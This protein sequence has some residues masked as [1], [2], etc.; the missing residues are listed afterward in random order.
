MNRVALLGNLARDPEVR[1]TSGE[2]QMAVCRFC[3]AVNRVPKREHQ[4]EADFIDC[5]AFG[6]TGETIANYFVKGSR[7]AVSGRLQKGSYIKDDETRYY[8]EV[9]V[10]GFDFC[11]S[12]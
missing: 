11:E 7:I 6:K 5:V 12:K 2:V 1:Y 3:I 9:V 8:T 4:P 10:E